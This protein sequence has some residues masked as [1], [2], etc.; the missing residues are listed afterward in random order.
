MTG[1]RHWAAPPPPPEDLAA[2]EAGR[3][4]SAHDEDARLVLALRDERQRAAAAAGLFA[5]H[6]R[7][8]YRIL[9]RALGAPEVTDLVQEVFLRVFARS[10][11]IEE[12]RAFQ[13]FLI[14]VTVR[15]LK[16]ELKKRQARRLIRLWAPAERPIEPAEQPDVEARELAR[17]LDRVLGGLTDRLRTVFVL[18]FVERLPVAEVAAALGVSHA[19]A[20]RWADQASAE[21]LEA[22]DGHPALL[23]HLRFRR[24]EGR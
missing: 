10:G 2:G 23:A 20:K 1:L 19:T 7:M 18:R 16:W 3:A 9:A 11:D 24:V 22:L 13:A 8:V 14:G 15:V 5:R 17:Q 6:S 21:V 12:P 4:A